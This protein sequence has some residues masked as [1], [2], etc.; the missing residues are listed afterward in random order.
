MLSATIF[1]GALRVKVYVYTAIFSA[2]R[3]YKITF[4]CNKMSTG[5]L[6]QHICDVTSNGVIAYTQI[7]RCVLK[8]CQTDKI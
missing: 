4:A 7:C 8:F 6:V 2:V 5:N 3:F 1:V